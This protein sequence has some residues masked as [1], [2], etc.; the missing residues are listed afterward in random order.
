MSILRKCHVT[1]S[2]R[3]RKGH[4]NFRGVHPYNNYLYITQHHTRW[5]G[6]ESYLLADLDRKGGGGGRGAQ[7]CGNLGY[8]CGLVVSYKTVLIDYP[9]VRN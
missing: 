4:V 3:S 7:I 1:M 9:P 5:R 6:L 2:F 8:A